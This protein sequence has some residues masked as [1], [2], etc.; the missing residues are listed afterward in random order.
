MQVRAGVGRDGVKA[1]GSG[2]ARARK[3]M[4]SQDRNASSEMPFQ[5]ARIAASP[6]VGRR[7]GAIGDRGHWHSVE[8]EFNRCGASTAGRSVRQLIEKHM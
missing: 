8:D 4:S 1:G 7:R 2:P 3:C 6:V 5:D